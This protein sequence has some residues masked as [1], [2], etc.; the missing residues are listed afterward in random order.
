MLIS[1]AFGNLQTSESVGDLFIFCPW[2]ARV[3]R[4]IILLMAHLD[5]CS[6]SD[7]KLIMFSLAEL[8]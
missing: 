1:G 2:T 3:S 4:R 7:S 6:K 8:N 5:N